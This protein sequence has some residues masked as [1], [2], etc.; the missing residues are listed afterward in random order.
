[1]L[2]GEFLQ[3]KRAEEE[4]NGREAAEDVYMDGKK[5]GIALANG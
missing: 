1:M 3:A 2:G 4:K 5:F